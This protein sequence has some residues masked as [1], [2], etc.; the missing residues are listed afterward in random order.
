MYPEVRAGVADFLVHGHLP[1]PR[2]TQALR[3]S[4]FSGYALYQ[5]RALRIVLHGDEAVAGA[6]K[7]RNHATEARWGL[8]GL[9]AFP[10]GCGSVLLAGHVRGRFGPPNTK[11][12]LVYVRFCK[13]SALLVSRRR[14]KYLNRSVR[15]APISQ[16]CDCGSGA[17]RQNRRQPFASCRSWSRRN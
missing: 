10:Q 4:Q 11:L 9:G 15:V 12:P 5:I 17:K 7:L 6:G 13:L 1:N 14:R 8:T 3:P 16:F 2:M